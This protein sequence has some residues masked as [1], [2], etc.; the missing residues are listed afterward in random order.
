[1]TDLWKDKVTVYII[2][3]NSSTSNSVRY[4]REIIYRC[5]IQCGCKEGMDGTIR[6]FADVK[7]IYTKD[8][9]RYLKPVDYFNLS[10]VKRMWDYP[11]G[12]YTVKIG[13]F[14]V[15]GKVN[16]VVSTP[17]EFSDLQTKYKDCGMKVTSINVNMFGMRTDH[18]MMTNA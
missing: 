17:K 13:D 3:V 12:C 18:I 9:G 4:R 8:V 2:E 15:F 16:D 5:N 11:N 1:M 7:T 14:I 10:E 6:N